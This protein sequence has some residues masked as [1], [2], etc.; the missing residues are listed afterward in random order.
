[1]EKFAYEL[2]RKYPKL[3]KITV[4]NPVPADPYVIA[5]VRHYLDLS[6]LDI[7]GKNVVMIT[8]DNPMLD[9]AKNFKINGKKLLSMFRNENWKF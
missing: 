3:G 6:T 1:M 5:A 2:I 4:R 7:D 8:D 9:V